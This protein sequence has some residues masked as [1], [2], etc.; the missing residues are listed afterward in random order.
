[1]DTRESRE[2][3]SALPASWVGI[4]YLMKKINNRLMERGIRNYNCVI[5]L[6][7]RNSRLAELQAPVPPLARGLRP[8]GSRAEATP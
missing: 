1:M 7:K 6:S 3:T 5:S 2:A 8:A 4:G